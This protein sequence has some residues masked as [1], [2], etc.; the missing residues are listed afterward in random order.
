M[1]SRTSDYEVRIDCAALPKTSDPI[2]HQFADI[3][4][5]EHHPSKPLADDRF[6]IPGEV[7]LLLGTSVFY[8]LLHS[9][10]MPLDACQAGAARN[11]FRLGVSK[12][13]EIEDFNPSQHLTKEEQFCEE[14][15]TKTTVRNASGRYIVKLPFIRDPTAIGE[16]GYSVLAQF[17]AMQR[18]L[19][20]DPEKYVLY[21]KY[22]EEFLANNHITRVAPDPNHPKIIYLAYHGVIKAESSTTKLR[23]VF[24]AAKKSSNGLSLNDLLAIGPI[25]QDTLYNFLMNFRLYPDERCDNPVTSTDELNQNVQVPR[26]FRVLSIAIDVGHKSFSYYANGVYYEP[27]CMNN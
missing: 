25:V 12:F 24:N 23:M 21:H 11:G 4:D 8:N 13:W 3:S 5:W 14:L 15:Y 17:T 20:R 9:D 26:G 18:Q 1:Q 2:P 16:T 22:V 10:R 6:N 27:E 7:D 19:Q